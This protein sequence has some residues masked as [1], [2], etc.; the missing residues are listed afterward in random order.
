[1]VS[2]S[3]NEPQ[4][5]GLPGWSPSWTSERYVQEGMCS[6]EAWPLRSGGFQPKG[7]ERDDTLW[8]TRERPHAREHTKKNPLTR[9]CWGHNGVN[10]KLAVEKIIN[11]STK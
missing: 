4:P 11:R 6:G 5:G 9:W 1:M 2:W 3:V 8:D 10:R 7:T